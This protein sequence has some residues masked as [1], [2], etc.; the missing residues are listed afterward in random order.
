MVNKYLK[1]IGNIKRYS[2]RTVEL[3]KDVLGGFFAF[4]APE[5]FNGAEAKAGGLPP[6]S[7]ETCKECLKANVIRGYEVCLADK[8]KLNAR[9]IGLHISALSGFSK[10]L[11]SQDVLESN[12]VKLVSRPKT[13]K[14]LPDVIKREDIATYIADT[15]DFI[16]NGLSEPLSNALYEKRL[17]RCIITLLFTT[18]IRRAELIGLKRSN[19]YP[20]RNVLRVTG[21]GDKMREIPLPEN[22]A[23]EISLYLHTIDDFIPGVHL[24]TG[25]LFLTATG[26]PL[27]PQYIE[28]IVKNEL[29]PYA[30]TS[31][32]LSP[33]VLRHSI[34]TALLSDGADLLSI[35]EF[36]GHSSLAATQVYTHNSIERLQEVYKNAHPR[37]KK[38]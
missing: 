35:K 23:K 15:D 20:G 27:Y 19:Y 31:G 18:G 16:F 5:V 11:I 7:E 26:K 1:Y 38:K 9:T 6:I 28:R 22:M 34:A 2:P 29:R 30:K 36:L 14:R 12:P 8:K 4:A 17:S 3:Y 10:W 13:S 25:E 37:E 33:H 21:K 24:M 32:K